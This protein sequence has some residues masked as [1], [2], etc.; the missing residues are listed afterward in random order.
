MS[1][2][3]HYGLVIT[4]SRN[5]EKS[6]FRWVSESYRDRYLVAHD[7]NT[8]GRVALVNF[9]YHLVDNTAVSMDVVRIFAPGIPV[10]WLD[11]IGHKRIEDIGTWAYNAE[12]EWEL[13]RSSKPLLA[14][15]ARMIYKGLPVIPDEME[16][17]AELTKAHIQY[18]WGKFSMEC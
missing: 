7:L 14:E 17:N 9:R 1:H 3:F 5:G 2:T 12:V 8:S 18:P 13:P 16:V 15:L 11:Y 6:S 10:N 4:I